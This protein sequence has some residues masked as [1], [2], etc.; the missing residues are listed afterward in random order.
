MEL[1]E[2]SERPDALLLRQEDEARFMQALKSLA[3]LHRE[4]LLL[5]FLEDFSL[6]EIAEVVG[7]ELGTVKS[8]I[9][10]AK[11]ALR[12]HLEAES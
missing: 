1:V 11:R 9:H 2:G 5:H 12:R 3:P 10:Y 6:Q 8:R 4:V 7:V